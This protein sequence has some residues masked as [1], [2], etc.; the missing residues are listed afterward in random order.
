MM[1]AALHPAQVSRFRL[2]TQELLLD[3]QTI[4]KPKNRF[5]RQNVSFIKRDN[6]HIKDVRRDSDHL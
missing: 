3:I 5:V 6:Q 1:T 4:D 2:F